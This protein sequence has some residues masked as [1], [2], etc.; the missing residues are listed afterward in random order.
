[1]DV[2]GAPEC[3]KIL[4]FMYSITN[5]ELIKHLHDKIPKSVDEMMR[6]ATTFLRGEVVAFSR[7]QKKS[8]M[9]WKQQEARHKQNFKKGGFRNQQRSERK[10]DRFTLLAKTPKEILALDKE[11]FKPPPSMTTPV[12]KRNAGKFCEFHGEVEEDGTK[13]L[14]I[15]EAEMGGY[16]VHRMYV[17]EGSYSKIMYEHC[18]NRFRPEVRSQMVP[19]ATPL[20]RFS[21][22]IIWLLE[23]ISL[24]VKIGD[25]EHLTFAWMNFMV[26][27]S[28]SPY[29]GIIERPGVRRIQAVPSTTHGMIKFPVTGRTITLRSSRI[30][31]LMH[32]GFRTRKEGRKELCGLLRRNLDI[33]AW[34]PLDMTRVSCHIAEH[35]LNIREG[36][37]PVRQKKM[38]QA[39]RRNKAIYEEV[40]KLVDVGIMK[41]D[42]CKGYHKI[43]M[44]KKDEENKAFI[45]SQGIFFYSKMSFR[46]KNTRSTYQRL[47]D[48]A[49]Q[50]QIGRNL[51]V[52]VDDLVVKC[53]TEQ[54]VIRDIE[55]TFKTL[56]DK[57]EV[58]PQKMHLWDERRHVS[59][60]PPRQ[61]NRVNNEADP[62][63]TAAVAQAVADLLPTLTARI[64]D[65]IRQNKN[66]GNNASTPVEAENWI[67][68]IEKI[69][70]VLGCG[71]QFK[72]R[73]ATYKLEGD[74]HSWWRAYKQAKGGDAYVATLPWNDF[75]DIFFLQYFPYSEKENV[76][77]PKMFTGNSLMK[78]SFSVCF[79]KK[80]VYRNSGWWMDDD[81]YFFFTKRAK[82]RMFIDLI[83]YS[84][85]NIAEEVND[86]PIE[87]HSSFLEPIL[88]LSPE[89]TI[90]ISS[91]S[92]QIV[93]LPLGKL[94]AATLPTKPIRVLKTRW[95]FSLNPGPFNLK[96]HVLI[97][98]FANSGS[99]SVYAVS[100][101]T[102][103]KAF[104]HLIPIAYWNNWYEAKRFPIYSSHVFD[105]YGGR[106]NVSRVLDS[107]TFSFD[108][109]GYSDYSKI[110][111]SIFFTFAYGLSFATLAATLSHVALFHGR[112][113][114]E[115]T[116]ASFKDKFGDVHTRIMKKNYDPVPQWWFYSILILVVGLAL[117][118]CEGFGGQL[119]LPYWG[120]LLGIGL[121]LVF[122]LPIGVIT[123]NNKP[124]FKLGHY[125]KIPPKSMFVVQLVGT[126]VASSIY[127]ATSWWLLT[128]VEYICD[129][130]NLPEGSPWT[131]PGDDVFYNASII[132]GVVG[133]QRMF[134][135]LG[136]YSKMNYFFLLGILAP[137]PVWFLSRKFPNR[138]WIRLINMPI[139][140]SG[141]GGMPPARAVN[142]NMWFAVGIFFNFV[143]YK[144]FK[145]WWARHNYILSAGLDAGVAFMA[146][147]C[148]FTLQ[149]RDI[150]GPKWWGMEIDDHCPLAGCPTAPGIKVDG[151]PQ[152]Y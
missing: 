12:E 151:C 124:D 74:A 81:V 149:I 61:R 4:G 27:R 59:R 45:T 111:L 32:N 121:A 26:V 48:K 42:A 106:Y 113:I 17:N 21:R 23:K 88:R 148:Y 97:T 129:P 100:I 152:V 54:E 101:I 19:A 25:D 137:V 72:A 104:Y 24:L 51:K 116:T 146:I 94:M 140:I 58:K 82:I 143:V 90:H 69:F 117:L 78:T 71:D 3:M 73:L 30:I 123:A 38:G 31:P 37:P 138:K 65:E 141:P 93:V 64:T 13:G 127:F 99:N 16:F 98:I 15:I 67:V 139:L 85:E 11:N 136:L 5:L 108:Q 118:T 77:V 110:N 56:R 76:D 62:I 128:T 87:Q 150:N 10:Q 84:Y 18:F 34:K 147:L 7:E 8:L 40:E 91:V 55:E 53:R 46:L 66:N 109:Q 80:D 20:V 2:K 103:V 39:P 43:K 89:S 41:E 135:N 114:W 52:Y 49:F 44:T 122:T 70:E 131:C 120:V 36:C 68:H 112:T 9:S 57:H 132:W 130:I 125:M 133:P 83:L 145:G 126:I 60:M 134:G 75:R 119:Q 105:A 33:F 115:Q 107:A 50:K 102:I 22:E 6:V 142:Y 79:S 144:K 28:P 63:F 47:V 95:S 1:M 92:A 86:S 29:N 35:G 96:E 14:M